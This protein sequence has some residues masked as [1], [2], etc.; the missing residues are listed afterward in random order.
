MESPLIAFGF[1]VC[2]VYLV[3]WFRGE[4]SGEL[5]EV[6]GV[7]WCEKWQDLEGAR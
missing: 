2:G 7:A 1:W 4:V 6:K 3:F 5:D